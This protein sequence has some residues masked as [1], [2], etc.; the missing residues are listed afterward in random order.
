[1]ASLRAYI[2]AY[3]IRSRSAALARARSAAD[4]RRIFET[5]AFRIRRA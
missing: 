2:G 4:F 3:M 1:M 5:P